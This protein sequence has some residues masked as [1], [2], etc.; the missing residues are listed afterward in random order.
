MAERLPAAHGGCAL[1]RGR[2]HREAEG[3]DLTIVSYANGVHLSLQAAL[4]LEREH[5]IRA[6]VVDLRW[7]APLDAELIAEQA[8]ATGRV[9]VVDEGRRSG[10]VGEAVITSLVERL[11]SKLPPLRRVCAE[12]T[13]IPLGPAADTVLPSVESI[14][15]A[16]VE[17]CGRE[18][19]S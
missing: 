8:A 18:R 1:G 10:G 12:D 14:A 11:G 6:R 3:G 13:Y 9:L 2:V 5:G 16:A 17:L 4:R 19:E 15:A 7:L